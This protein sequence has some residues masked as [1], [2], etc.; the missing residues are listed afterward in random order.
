MLLAQP[1]SLLLEP[2]DEVR[3]MPKGFPKH[4]PKKLR[5]P[6]INE[7]SPGKKNLQV[8]MNFSV[9]EKSQK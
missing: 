2:P 4:P 9:D 1:S 8:Q 5:Q 6:K 7:P 3:I